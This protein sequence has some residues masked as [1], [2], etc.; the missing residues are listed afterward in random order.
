MRCELN[1]TANVTRV[2]EGGEVGLEEGKLQD[3][4]QRP[5]RVMEG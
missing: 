2:Q 5:A 1:G 4:V 3:R